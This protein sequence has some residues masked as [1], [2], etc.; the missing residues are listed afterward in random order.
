MHQAIYIFNFFNLITLSFVIHEY[1][2]NR[3]KSCKIMKTNKKYTQMFEVTSAHTIMRFK[4]TTKQHCTVVNII[5]N[6][7]NLAA[8]LR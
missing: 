7:R 6:A 3:G 5:V 4:G 2:L 8:S 1:S